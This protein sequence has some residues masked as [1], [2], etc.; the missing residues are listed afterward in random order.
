[1]SATFDALKRD[2]DDIRQLPTTVDALQG[3]QNNMPTTVDA[4]K[5]DQDD[6]R[7]LY[8]TVDALQGY[9]ND[10]STTVDAL[11]LDQ[12]D[13]RQLSTTVDAMKRDQDK[14]RQLSNTV[15]ALK[16]DQNDM[17]TTLDAFK[18]DK[19]RMRQLSTTVEALKRDLDKERSRTTA[20]EQRLLEMSNSTAPCPRGY[21]V[22]RGIC[23]KAFKKGR[24]TFVGAGA[25]CRQHGG[26]LAMPRDAEINKFLLSF[27]KSGHFWFGLHYQREEGSFEWVDGSALGTYSYWGPGEPKKRERKRFDCVYYSMLMEHKWAV[28][29][30][31]LWSR[32]S[33]ICQVVPGSICV[34]ASTVKL[35]SEM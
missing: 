4:L 27:V 26:T 11:K 9:Q 28:G 14:I 12:N 25:A 1:M 15:D 10:M 31:D 8:N 34:T 21:K 35:A 18:R 30:C 24:L 19:D 33:F 6:I 29:A 32:R 13:I 17:S 22:F 23:Y 5:R 3:Y 2:Q 7:Q 20:L 16:R